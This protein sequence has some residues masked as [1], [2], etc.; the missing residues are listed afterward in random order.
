VKG[1]EKRGGKNSE[2][3][4][5]KREN[6]G[7]FSAREKSRAFAQK[8][9]FAKPGGVRDKKGT[10]QPSDKTGPRVGAGPR[11]ERRSTM[12]CDWLVWEGRGCAYSTF[13]C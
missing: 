5:G 11:P 6:G 9:R 8:K 7:D 13:W 2:K 12:A 4:K 10:R 1:K 3:D